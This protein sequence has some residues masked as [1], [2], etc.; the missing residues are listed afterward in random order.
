LLLVATHG[1]LR[2]TATAIYAASVSGLFGVSALYHLGNWRPA[3]QAVLQRVD[4]LMIFVLIAGTAT[5]MF[6]IATPSTYGRICLAAMWALT[7]VAA[8]VHGLWMHAPER[9]VGAV[10]IGLGATAALALPPV[11]ARSGSAAGVL[12]ICGGV[13]YILGAVSYH[14]RWP[15]PAPARFG[16]H[17]VFHA[18]VCIAASC[19]YVAIA[20]LVL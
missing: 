4:H 1:A 7:T 20:L 2:V 13:L 14:R 5:P 3:A 19:H 10:F 15:D 11:W 16:Y 18:F 9:L 12:I 8:V 17:E 6:L